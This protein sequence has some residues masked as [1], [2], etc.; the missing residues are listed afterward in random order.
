MIEIYT[1]IHVHSHFSMGDAILRIPNYIKKCEQL[2]I[3]S[4]SL[5]EH[6]NLC[7]S[8]LFSRECLN[9]GIKAIIGCEVYISES[10]DTVEEIKVAAKEKKEEEGHEAERQ[11]LRSHLLLIAKDYKG[12]SNLVNLTNEAFKERFYRK[13]LTLHRLVLEKGEGLI[14]TTACLASAFSQACENDNYKKFIGLLSQYKEAFKND[15]YLEIQI[16]ERDEL[17]KYNDWLIKASKGLKINL[18][19]GLDAHYLDKED[20]YMRDV[21]LAIQRKKTINDKDF[22]SDIKDLHVK[23]IKEICNQNI[24]D[25]KILEEALEN[26]NE[27]A[28]KCSFS[29]TFDGYKFPKLDT[30]KIQTELITI[31]LNRLEQLELPEDKKD[32]YMQRLKYE[33]KVLKKHNLF[34][35]FY[36]L[37]EALQQVRNNNGLVGYGRGSA[38]GSLFCYLADITYVDP[39]KFGLSFER[40]INEDRGKIQMKLDIE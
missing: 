29:F 40:F 37:R 20:A 27:I 10:G 14:V 17:L 28:E 18:V 31:T 6:G 5:T 33:L 25:P 24:I 8:Y 32:V 35:Y 15:F 19:F 12:Y 23:T 7:S 34:G 36:I 4:A 30:K 22:A 39:L 21:A 1:P 26:T 2:N 3:K 16:N 13:P 9:A 11:K 38:A